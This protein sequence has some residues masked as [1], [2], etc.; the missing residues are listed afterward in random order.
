MNAK[1]Q[2]INW[3]FMTLRKAAWAPLGS[4]AFMQLGSLLICMIDSR[5]W[6]S[7]VIY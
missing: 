2:L 6:I 5:R 3:V 1:Q 4:S 7:Q